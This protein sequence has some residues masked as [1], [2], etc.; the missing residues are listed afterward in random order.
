[1][2]FKDILVHVDATPASRTRIQ[3][4]LTLARR[5]DAGLLGL[6]VIPEPDVRLISNR[7]S[8]SGLPRFTR[9]MPEWR[10]IWPPRRCRRSQGDH[11]I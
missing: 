2:S 11:P 4:A 10:L 8:S 9:K 5:F 1:M 7:A 6:H 3:L